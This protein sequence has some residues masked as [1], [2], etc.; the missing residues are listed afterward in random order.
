M[1]GEKISMFRVPQGV[2]R[3]NQR[4]HSSKTAKMKDVQSKVMFKSFLFDIC[5]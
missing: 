2:G 1:A 4:A 3:P 5:F